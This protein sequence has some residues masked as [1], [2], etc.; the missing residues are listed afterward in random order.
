MIHKNSEDFSVR[1][2]LAILYIHS[3]TVCV[4]VCVCVTESELVCNICISQSLYY[5]HVHVCITI[6]TMAH[7]ISKF[8][9]IIEQYVYSVTHNSMICSVA[10]ND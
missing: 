6:P 2:F 8:T 9:S 5:V 3:A 1:K 10:C 7:L 4:C